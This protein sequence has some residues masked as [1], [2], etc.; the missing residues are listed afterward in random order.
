MKPVYFSGSISGGRGDVELYIEIVEYVRSL[1]YDV[2]AGQVI[3]RE[4][5]SAGGEPLDDRTIFERDMGWLEKVAKGG[6]L[7]LAEVSTPSL[8][9]GYE[10]A[11]ARYHYAIPVICLHRSESGRRCSAM[12]AGDPGIRLIRYSATKIERMYEE[13]K[14]ALHELAE[15]E[16]GE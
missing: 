1:R 16:V 6:G 11:A 10:I 15:F 3:N 8:G 12:I 9:V 5:P 13:L 7:L 4:L 2:N 14:A